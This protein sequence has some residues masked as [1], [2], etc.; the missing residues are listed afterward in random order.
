MAF[1]IAASTRSGRCRSSTERFAR[2]EM[3]VGARLSN[4]LHARMLVAVTKWRRRPAQTEAS[5]RRRR[6]HEST[7]NPFRTRGL[8]CNSFRA[9]VAELADAGDLKSP[10]SCEACGFDSRPRHHL[11]SRTY[12]REERRGW[13]VPS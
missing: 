13:K 7:S 8:A 9:G 4:A 2:T 10:A 1:F 3:W 5:S 11:F 12:E 6:E